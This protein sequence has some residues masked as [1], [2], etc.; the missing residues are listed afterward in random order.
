MSLF[1]PKGV[2][3]RRGKKAGPPRSSRIY[4]SEVG[5]WSQA[6][7]GSGMQCPPVLEIRPTPKAAGVT[8]GV[9][10]LIFQKTCR[11]DLRHADTFAW[12]ECVHCKSC[13]CPSFSLDDL[14]DMPAEVLE[15][16]KLH[17]ELC[18]KLER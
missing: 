12:Y 14:K 3:D 5:Y 9:R 6:E 1:R 10:S 16:L 13:G 15:H 8:E 18:S 7:R 17:A 11:F 2:W 4:L